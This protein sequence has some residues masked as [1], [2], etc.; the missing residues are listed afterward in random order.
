MQPLVFFPTP[1]ET[2][3]CPFQAWSLFVRIVLGHLASTLRWM[4]EVAPLTDIGDVNPSLWLDFLEARL[5]AG[6]HPN[7]INGQLSGSSL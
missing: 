6:I 7:T 3:Y 4:T 5:A 2:F 1:F